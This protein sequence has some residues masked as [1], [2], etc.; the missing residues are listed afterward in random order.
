M[1]SF[2]KRARDNRHCSQTLTAIAGLSSSPTGFTRLRW[3][4]KGDGKHFRA[5]VEQNVPTSDPTLQL[6]AGQDLLRE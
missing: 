5:V 3:G 2:V 1:I 6:V 4:S